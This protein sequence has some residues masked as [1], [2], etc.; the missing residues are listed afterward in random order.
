MRLVAFNA[1]KRIVT[2]M[3]NSG[4]EAAILQVFGGQARELHVVL[5]NQ[6]AKRLPGGGLYVNV[7]RVRGRTQRVARGSHYFTCQFI[8]ISAGYW[9]SRVPGNLDY[10]RQSRTRSSRI[11][12]NSA[13]GVLIENSAAQRRGSD[14]GPI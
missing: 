10:S 13:D 12:G 9:H 5:N 11:K 6:H 8:S 14:A 3:F 4:K 7:R 2:T 1:G